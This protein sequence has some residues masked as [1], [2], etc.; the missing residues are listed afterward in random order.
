LLPLRATTALSFLTLFTIKKKKLNDAT[1]SPGLPS[2]VSKSPTTEERKLSFSL[3]SKNKLQ[4]YEIDWLNPLVISSES[5]KY[6]KNNE[7]LPNTHESQL[8]FLMNKFD[9]GEIKLSF[10][11]TIG[12]IGHTATKLCYPLPAQKDKIILKFIQLV[13]SVMIFSVRKTEM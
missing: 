3:T 11:N 7:T 13:L 5:I 1:S 8:S 9:P 2:Q 12:K 6:L 10:S 4:H